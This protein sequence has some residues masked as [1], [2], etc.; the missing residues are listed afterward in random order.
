MTQEEKTFYG[1]ETSYSNYI[2]PTHKAILTMNEFINNPKSF[3]AQNYIVN[4]SQKQ[5][6]K[7]YM[8]TFNEYCSVKN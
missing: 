2:L 8:D 3:E 4:E 5:R 6:I 7:Y 1:N